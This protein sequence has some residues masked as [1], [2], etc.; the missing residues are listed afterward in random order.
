MIFNGIY[1]GDHGTLEIDPMAYCPDLVLLIAPL[2]LDTTT[3]CFQALS[4]PNIT[5]EFGE[6]SVT[7]FGKV[8]SGVSVNLILS[9]LIADLEVDDILNQSQHLNLASPYQ[10]Q[11][12]KSNPHAEDAMIDQDTFW[13]YISKFFVSGDIIMKETGTASSGGLDFMLPPQ[14]TMINSAA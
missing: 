9:K 3:C 4:R 5:I 1:E 7:V 8:H 6:T 12:V 10:D 2:K 13:A 14:T 11:A